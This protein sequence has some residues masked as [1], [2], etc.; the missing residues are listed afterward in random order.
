MRGFAMHLKGL[1]LNLLVV[2]DALLTEKSVTRTGMRINLSQ[3]ATSGCL[4]R[5]REF[6]NDPLLIQVGQ[7]MELTPLAERLAQPIRE[8]VLKGEAIVEKNQGFRPN[9]STRTFRLNMSDYEAAVLMNRAL[10]RIREFAPFVQVAIT[11][12]VDQP[13]REYLDRGYLDLIVTPAEHTSQHHPSER[14]FDDR[15]VAVVWSQNP[16]AREGLTLDTYLAGGHIAAYLGQL[17]GWSFDEVF[18]TRS[19]YQRRIEVVVP[20]FSMIFS[21]IVGSQLIATVQERLA[22][23]YAQYFPISIFPCPIPIPRIETRLQWHRSHD[24]DPGIQWLRQML[25]DTAA[26]L[27]PCSVGAEIKRE[28]DNQST[29]EAAGESSQSTP[30]PLIA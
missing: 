10:P 25:R 29:A 2:L 3:S 24:G 11:S 8:L 20:S 13:T 26:E 5:L 23:F 30:S 7:R 22:R 1:D 19:G 14:L 28:N 15:C 9:E 12:I 18:A 21:Q 16:I 6:F 4:A 17:I 27:E